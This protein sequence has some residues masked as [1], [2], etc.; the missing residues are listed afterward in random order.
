MRVACCATALMRPEIQ[1]ERL[2]Q[3]FVIDLADGALPGRA[4]I[5]DH[6][7]HAA[8]GRD[9]GIERRAHALRIGDVAF[10]R[11]RL[12]AD[13]LRRRLGRFQVAVQDGDFRAFLGHRLGGGGA[14]ARTAA[15]DHRHLAGQRLFV[16]LAQLGLFQ[17]PVFHFEHVEFADA[18]IFA[19]R[20]GIGDDGDGILGDVGGDGGVLGA[21]ADAEH[22]DARHQDD[23][24]QRDRVPSSSPAL[25]ALLSLEI[26]VIAR[27]IG[28]DRRMHVLRPLFQLAGFRRRHDHRPVLGADGVVGRHHADLAVARQFRAVHIVQDLRDWCGNPGSGAW[29]CRPSAF[30]S[31]AT[32]PRRM[33]AISGTLR[34]IWRAASP[35]PATCAAASAALPPW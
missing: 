29:R 21:G 32:A 34:Q 5:G 6:D 17:R 9:H 3:G 25:L 26:A 16:G 27:D 20:L 14:D 13:L 31:I 12:A 7:I 24:R 15:G 4:R 18:A 10:H 1:L 2:A 22:A 30:F 33:G 8:K 35:A 23:A 11:Q 28:L 19:H